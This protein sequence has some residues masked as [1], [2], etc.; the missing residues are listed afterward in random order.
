MN[1]FGLDFPFFTKK[2]EIKYKTGEPSLL[3][4]LYG[5]QTSLD[6]LENYLLGLGDSDL[7]NQIKILTALAKENEYIC[8]GLSNAIKI[9]NTPFEIEF[10]DKVSAREAK[11]M[12]QD[13]EDHKNTWCIGG[14]SALVKSLFYNLILKGASCTETPLDIRRKTAYHKTIRIEDIYIQ[15]LPNGKYKL[16]QMSGAGVT[17]LGSQVFYIPYETD[18]IDPYAVP[19]MIT[20]I[21][22]AYIQQKAK[23]SFTTMIKH[24]G[25]LGVLSINLKRPQRLQ[26]EDDATYAKR[27][28]DNLLI[29]YRNMANG[30]ANGITVGYEEMTNFQ[31]I[32]ANMNSANAVNLAN[33]INQMMATSIKTN[34]SML[35]SDEG[36]T[37]AFGEVVLN[38]K[39]MEAYDFQRPAA[40]AYEWHLMLF[41]LNRGHRPRTVT[42]RFERPN[43]TDLKKEEETYSIKINN[44]KT[45]YT[46]GIIDQ[47]EYARIAGYEKPDLP[48]ARSDEPATSAA[49]QSQNYSYLG[50][51]LKQAI[52]D[53]H[54][55]SKELVFEGE[56]SSFGDA[57][58]DRIN[59]SYQRDVLEAFEIETNKALRKIKAT[60]RG[61]EF[62][63]KETF[64]KTIIGTF[65][66]AFE[67]NFEKRIKPFTKLYPDKAYTTFR[68]DKK[69]FGQETQT[70]NSVEGKTKTTQYAGVYPDAVL[71]TMD[72]KL[73]EFFKD[74]DQ[75]YLGKFITEPETI[76]R[77]ADWLAKWYGENAGELGKD[78]ETLNRFIDEFEEV[79]KGNAYVIRRVIE[80]TLNNA[81]GFASVKYIDQAGV[82]KFKRVEVMDRLTCPHCRAVDGRIF[83]V[84]QELEKAE[85]YV[86]A[87]P[88]NVGD[89]SPFATTISIERFRQ[90]DATQMQASGVGVQAMHPHCRGRIIAFFDS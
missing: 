2:K 74:N 80:T 22:N 89:I 41:L 85:Q 63:N 40:A 12:Y 16:A 49:T 15:T 30:I 60:L 53:N 50:T 84:K 51:E 10:S 14:E 73:I 45:L 61:K 58:L 48:Q 31:V 52:L 29:Q 7:R 25:M 37:R 33:I 44:A 55:L 34:P 17:E 59:K 68:K 8:Y 87:T 36:S 66:K 9:A 62:H 18:G 47:Q 56:G 21:D 24:L 71:D 6:D 75:L 42:V 20:A 57:K 32:G 90:M 26:G 13:I 76:K 86:K 88:Q 65:N 78:S 83:E 35:G 38:Q 72:Y 11:L 19:P 79:V 69:V 27:L 3:S 39:I 82:E 64:T 23:R 5:G 81:R 46:D 43:I 70:Q 54:F 67:S 4:E 77:F 28:N 1:F